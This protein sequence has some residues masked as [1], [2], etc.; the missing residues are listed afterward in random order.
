MKIAV[1]IHATILYTA[2]KNKVDKHTQLKHRKSHKKSLPWFNESLWDTMKQRDK[3]LKVSL[4]SKLTTDYYIY[5]SLRNKVTML[6]RKAKTIFFLNLI[7]EANGNCKNLWRSM[8][9]LLGRQKINQELL[10]LKINGI[11]QNESSI[12]AKHYNDYFLDSVLDL[13]ETFPEVNCCR[14]DH[15]DVNA[16][17]FRLQNID[18]DKI[19]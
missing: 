1:Y 15:G 10:Q 5:K 19:F 9:K 11:V 18:E 13:A 3:A 14:D 6:L 16:S 2:I 7:K 4:K 8:D 12:L 17:Y